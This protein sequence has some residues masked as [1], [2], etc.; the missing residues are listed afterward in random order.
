MLG[1]AKAQIMGNLTRDPETRTT[2]SGKTVVSFSLA[3]NNKRETPA[4][5]YDC[6]AWEQTGE[7]IARYCQ[8]G[9]PLMVEGTLNASEYEVKGEKRR[10]VELVVR[11]FYF[12]GGKDDAQGDTRLIQQHEV[13]EKTRDVAPIDV[14]DKPID[15]SEIPF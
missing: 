8:K 5:F 13:I 4:Q 6:V 9:K 2:A 10:K 14:E 7:L 15:L 3:V 12:L 1:F 11:E